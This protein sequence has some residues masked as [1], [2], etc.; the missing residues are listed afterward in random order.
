MAGEFTNSPGV[1]SNKEIRR[2]TNS[3][4]SK[5]KLN[6]T[7]MYKYFGGYGDGFNIVA[8]DDADTFK[9]KME[10]ANDR[11]LGGT[12]VW[13]IDFDSEP[14]GE[15]NDNSGPPR[16][17]GFDTTVT[18]YDDDQISEAM[19]DEN[20][21]NTLNEFCSQTAGTWNNK[22]TE[23]RRKDFRNPRDNIGYTIFTSGGI[24]AGCEAHMRMVSDIFLSLFPILR[25]HDSNSA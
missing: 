14:G 19:S 5:P 22:K 9:V 1:L 11:C 23:N 12:M 8:Y 13:S 20:L 17:P 18:C 4:N 16:S 7:G 2:M 25:K 15:Y 21:E 3:P 10:Y 6:E 24:Q